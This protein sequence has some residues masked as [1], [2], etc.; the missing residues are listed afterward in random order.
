[1]EGIIL[2]I[3]AN[4]FFIYAHDTFDTKHSKNVYVPIVHRF[5]PIKEQYPPMVLS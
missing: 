4:S 3:P 2:T 1:M 5:E